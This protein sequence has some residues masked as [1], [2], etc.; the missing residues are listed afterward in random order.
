M[1]FN[2]L[3]FLP[4]FVIA[5]A[6]PRLLPWR[7]AKWFLMV[8]SW[9]FYASFNPPYLLLLLT[10]TV[11]DYWF[12]NIIYRATTPHAKRLC[13]IASC[14]VNLAFLGFF[15][16]GDFLLG[17]SSDLSVWSG[18]RPFDYRF[19]FVLPVGI[20]FYTFQSLSYTI[21]VY[22]GLLKPYTF[23]DFAL[24]VSFFP[25]LVAGPIVRARDFLH[26]LRVRGRTTFLRS[27]LAVYLIVLGYFKKVVLADGVAPSV[28]IYCDFSGYSDIAIGLSLL[29]GFYIR[30][31]FNLPYLALGLSDFWRRWHISL[32]SW[33]RDYLYIPLGGNRGTQLRRAYTLVLT[34]TLCGLWHGATWMFVVW[35]FYHGVMM[36]I[37]RYIVR[38]LGRAEAVVP[39]LA[40]LRKTIVWRALVVIVTFVVVILGWVFFRADSLA[41]ATTIFGKLAQLGPGS[42]W[43]LVLESPVFAPVAIV[44]A[45]HAALFFRVHVARRR[46]LHWSYYTAVAA[47]MLFF[48]VTA[49]N[50]TNA[51]IY[52]QF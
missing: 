32:S 39:V 24:Y 23:L 52:F 21:D 46:R 43:G 36:L 14:V 47:T 10:S 50:S 2:T 28:Q 27:S 31:N 20:S 33:I 4:F 7:A 41:T 5:M 44:A 6:V 37:E 9:L 45:V 16:Y 29:L 17:T 25:H 1:I 11:L 22:R 49:W 3:Q 38:G 42:P 15:K 40:E 35:G 13:L 8:A 26:Q 19:D 34:M 51:F 18:G 12:G 30:K 48:V